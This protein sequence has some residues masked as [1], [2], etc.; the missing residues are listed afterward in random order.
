MI[1]C[2]LQFEIFTILNSLQFSIKLNQIKCWFLE[3]GENRSTRRKTSR[4]RVENQQTQ[5]TY[6]A[7]CGN[8]TRDTLVEGER[9]HHCVNPA[10]LSLI[11]NKLAYCHFTTVLVSTLAFGSSLTMALHTICFARSAYL[12]KKMTKPYINN[13]MSNKNTKTGRSTE[14]NLIMLCHCLVYNFQCSL[15]DAGYVGH[16]CGHL[17]ECAAAHKQISSPIYKHYENEHNNKLIVST[18]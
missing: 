12:V 15:C 6:D 18:F 2:A 11:G 16:T 1:K 7:E 13:V 9:S 5:P 14:D 10:A 3:R 8:R 17:H 4:S